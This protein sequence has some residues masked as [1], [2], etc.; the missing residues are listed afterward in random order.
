MRRMRIACWINK[1]TDT[2]SEYVTIT[3]F[4]QEQRLGKSARMLH[5]YV[6]CRHVILHIYY[7][8]TRSH[9]RS[10]LSLRA[11][12]GLSSLIAVETVDD[13]P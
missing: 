4:P 8:I 1:T 13:P 3:A 5:Q 11:Y 2:R 12:G 6:H 9:R 7:T 10:D